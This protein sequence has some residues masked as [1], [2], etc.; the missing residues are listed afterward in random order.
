MS[1]ELSFI[2][3]KSKGEDIIYLLWTT[4]PTVTSNVK[5]INCK[6]TRGPNYRMKLCKVGKSPLFAVQPWG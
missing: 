1:S 4:N 6:H 5:Q 3:H 2:S